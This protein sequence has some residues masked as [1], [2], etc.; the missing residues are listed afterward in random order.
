MKYFMGID[1]GKTGAIAV[2][3]SDGFAQVWDYPG[4]LAEAGVLLRSI[5]IQCSISLCAVEKV[6]TMPKQGIVSAFTF[7]MNFGG[8]LM[9]LGALGTPHVTVTPRTW[10]KEC[11]D[12]GTGETKERS[13]SVARRRFPDIDLSKKKHDGRAD[14]LH[15]ARWAMIE[16]RRGT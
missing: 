6:G 14:A 8:W 4:E 12:S 10:Q 3:G 5:C 1:P 9:T 13:L 7:G 16:Y 2:I 11:L 15:L